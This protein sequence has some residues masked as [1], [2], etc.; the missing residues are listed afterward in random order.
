MLLLLLVALSSLSLSLN[1]LRTAL[2]RPRAIA[3]RT[4]INFLCV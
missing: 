3:Q 1:A 2:R 4:L